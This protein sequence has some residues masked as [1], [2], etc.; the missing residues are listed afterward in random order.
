MWF[1]S[2]PVL[3]FSIT[4]P[5]HSLTGFI[6]I[7]GQL[8]TLTEIS[9]KL[10]GN[11]LKKTSAKKSVALEKHSPVVLRTVMDLAG[12][13]AV[14]AL[15]VSAEPA[16]K[17]TVGRLLHMQQVISSTSAPFRT[18]LQHTRIKCLTH[19]HS[20]RSGSSDVA[21]KLDVSCVLSDMQ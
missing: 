9:N 6:R 7:F 1:N 17:Q 16:R 20:F 3:F 12:L 21:Q 18:E 2:S 13:T 19:F 8:R 15:Q 11:L 14:T 10:L 4:V 5:P